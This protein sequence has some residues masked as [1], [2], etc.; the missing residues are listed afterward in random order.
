MTSYIVRIYRRDE[1]THEIVGLVESPESCERM[2]F[3]S[4]AQLREI[5]NT[6]MRELKRC[7][8]ASIADVDMITFT[9][10]DGSG[11]NGGRS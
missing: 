2:P 4:F 3:Q 9:A 7:S 5:L 10:D 11:G 8:D 6:D 1:S